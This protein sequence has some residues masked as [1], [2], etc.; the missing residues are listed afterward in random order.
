MN[1]PTCTVCNDTLCGGTGLCEHCSDYYDS[2][3]NPPDNYYYSRCPNCNS[4]MED[5]SCKYTCRYCNYFESCN[6]G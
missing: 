2:K 5:F 6:E 4:P 1:N 3:L